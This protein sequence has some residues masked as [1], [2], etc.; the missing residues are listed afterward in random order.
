MKKNRWFPHFLSIS[1]I[2]TLVIFLAC[3]RQPT[4][5]LEEHDPIVKK[6]EEQDSIRVI[7]INK[8]S[9]QKVK[10]DKIKK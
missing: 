7:K 6:L 9:L 5:V 4:K 1:F 10:R 3:N 8:D 2:L